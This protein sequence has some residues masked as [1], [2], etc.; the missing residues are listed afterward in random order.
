MV[1]QNIIFN[2]I[3]NAL[4]KELQQKYNNIHKKLSSLKATQLKSTY[5]GSPISFYPSY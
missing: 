4:H 2:D 3:E 5:T 1:G